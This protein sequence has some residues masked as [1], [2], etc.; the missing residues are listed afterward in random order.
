MRQKTGRPYFLYADPDCRCVF[1]GS[2]KAMSSYRQMMAQE[3]PGYQDFLGAR[4]GQR[5][6][7]GRAESEIVREMDQDAGLL[8]EDDILHPGF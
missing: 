3:P 6:P 8:D 4:T 5:L 2:E 7:G 1:V